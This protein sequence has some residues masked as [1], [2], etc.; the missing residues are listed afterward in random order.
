MGTVATH[1]LNPL[2]L[3]TRSY[4]PVADFAPVSLRV[5]VPNVLAVSLE[6]PVHSVQNLIDLA[7]SRLPKRG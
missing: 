1:E 5:L 6:L 7:K 3:K 2:I 4:D